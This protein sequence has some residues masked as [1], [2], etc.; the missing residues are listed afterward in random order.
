MRTLLRKIAVFYRDDCCWPYALSFYLVLII[1]AMDF[2]GVP[3]PYHGASVFSFG[4]LLAY[5]LYNLRLYFRKDIRIMEKK[6]PV[7]FI[8]FLSSKIALWGLAL[9]LLGAGL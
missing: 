1:F 8:G 4:I 9:V 5:Y 2:G 3:T 7:F 6:D